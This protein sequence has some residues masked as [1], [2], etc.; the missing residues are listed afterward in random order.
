MIP[1][2]DFVTLLTPGYLSDSFEIVRTLSAR[3]GIDIQVKTS[4]RKILSVNGR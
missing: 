3:I 1:M 4:S 2:Y